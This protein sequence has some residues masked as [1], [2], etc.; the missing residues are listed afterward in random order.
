MTPTDSPDA[1]VNM[2]SICVVHFVV[3]PIIYY[4]LGAIPLKRYSFQLLQFFLNFVLCEHLN[5]RTSSDT[6]G[7]YMGNVT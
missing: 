6:C 5:P 3:L 4:F 7:P 2:S 1:D